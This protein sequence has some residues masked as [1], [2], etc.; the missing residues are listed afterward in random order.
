MVCPGNFPQPATGYAMQDKGV[1]SKKCVLK[2]D[3]VKVG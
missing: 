3:E 1:K 2:K